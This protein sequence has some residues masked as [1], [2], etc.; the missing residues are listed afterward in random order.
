MITQRYGGFKIL[1]H[2]QKLKDLLEGK[3]SAPIYVRVKPTNKCNHHCSFCSYDPKTGDKTIRDGMN[4][5]RA[6]IPKDKMMEVL[7]DLSDIEVK[8]VTYSGGGEPLMYPYIN[9]AMRKTLEYGINLSIITNGQN[10]NEKSA[11]IL[12]N[13]HW[14]RISA[15][16]S[17]AKS[18]RKIRA[19]PESWFYELEK[20]I[21]D[22]ARKKSSKCELGINFVVQIE[23]ADQIYR[24]VEYFR[25]LG[26][27]HIKIT[28]MWNQDFL[29][30]HLPIKERVLEQV[31]KAR[32][33]FSDDKF[34]VYDTYEND[35]SLSSVSERKYTRCYIMQ[36]VPVIGADCKVYFC[37][38]KAYS[39]EGTL[40]SIEEKSFKDL[41]FSEES[42]RIFETFNPKESCRHHCANDS[43]NVLLNKA[44]DCYGDDI[45]FI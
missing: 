6:E 10:L 41:W 37:H 24:S 7:S 9:E 12:T 39:T 15:N 22:F 8:A 20:N 44:I 13:S 27:N 28:P 40:G 33:D 17:D 3:V 26:V 11:E 43:K 42:A 30:Y 18:F 36:T 35:F 29:R 45:N 5:R 38:D 23:N 32:D 19:V 14:T 31:K 34:I 21:A 25:N 4:D 16:A 2:Q 1:W